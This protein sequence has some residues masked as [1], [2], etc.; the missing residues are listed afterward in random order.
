MEV[1]MSN[2]TVIVPTLNE[3]KYLGNLLTS[4]EKQDYRD[5]DVIV[6]DGGSQDKTLSISQAFGAQTVV[7]P[8]CK[9]YPS[10]NKAAE[11]A[12]GN[13]LFFTGADVVFPDNMLRN[14]ARKFEDPELL[15][16]A[17]PGIPYDGSILLKIEFF[18]YN[19]LRCF[20][21]LLPK[22]LK[23][24][25]TST[26]LLAVRK[27]AF[28][29]VGGLD[30]N[31]INADGMLGR[32]LCNSGRVWFSFFKVKA[33]NSTRRVKAMGAVDFNKHFIYVLENF[34]PF[35]SN[36]SF[37]RTNKFSSGESHSM[38]RKKAA[39]PVE[40]YQE[41]GS[42]NQEVDSTTNLETAT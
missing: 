31:D 7:I 12:S 4:L 22:P 35:L 14:V 32:K 21:A 40:V 20:F 26:G 19:S 2:I 24:F 39:M 17:G 15:A 6:V 28:N 34:F 16:V 11:L 29:S 42:Q 10:R 5:F 3:D 18:L 13:I 37:I 38:M 8:K 25:S 27:S 41:F 1:D 33:Y 23:R 30:P 9:E 36:T